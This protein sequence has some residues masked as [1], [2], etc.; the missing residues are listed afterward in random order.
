MCSR[1][2]RPVTFSCGSWPRIRPDNEI[3]AR[4]TNVNQLWV[5]AYHH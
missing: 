1:L 3:R 5:K 4:K 2:W